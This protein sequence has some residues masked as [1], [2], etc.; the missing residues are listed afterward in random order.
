MVVVLGGA[1]RVLSLIARVL[2][3]GFCM[4]SQRYSSFQSAPF[5]PPPLVALGDLCLL[6]HDRNMSQIIQILM[7]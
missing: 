5:P 3:V 6:W 1:R 7:R 2:L 4:V